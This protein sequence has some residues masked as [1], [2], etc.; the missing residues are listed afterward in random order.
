MAS[1]KIVAVWAHLTCGS[2]PALADL[3]DDTTVILNRAFSRK[4]L[5]IMERGRNEKLHSKIRKRSLHI[6]TQVYRNNT[7]MCSKKSE[8]DKLTGKNEQIP[9]TRYALKSI[10]ASEELCP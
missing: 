2:S 5:L 6:Y 7:S 9:G 1:R 10:L 8:N 4:L 3:R